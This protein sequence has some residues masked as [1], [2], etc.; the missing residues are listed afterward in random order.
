MARTGR[1]KKVFDL[2][3]LE[4]LA[5]MHFTEEEVATWF[6]VAVRTIHRKKKNADF[7]AALVG[8]RLKGKVSIRRLQFEAAQRGNI[9]MLIWLGKQYLGQMNI[10]HDRS[11]GHP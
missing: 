1:P 5:M 2:A 8:G 10:V 4:K 7:L 3:Q 6:G 9:T 11:S